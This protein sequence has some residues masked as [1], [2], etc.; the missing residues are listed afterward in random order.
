MT[1]RRRI[2]ITL[3]VS[4]QDIA[5]KEGR[6]CVSHLSLACAILKE[7]FCTAGGTS[8]KQED[9]PGKE[10]RDMADLLSG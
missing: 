8:L 7:F 5:R 1:V 9:T 10:E 4:R 6:S 3:D 2:E